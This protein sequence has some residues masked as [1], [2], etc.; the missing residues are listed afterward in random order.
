MNETYSLHSEF[1]VRQHKKTFINYLEV[2]IEESGKIVYAVPSHQETL[3]RNACKKY[4]ITRDELLKTVP[5]EW[6]FDFMIWLCKETGCCCVW[7]KF[8][9]G[10][11]FTQNQVKALRMLK[12]NGIYHGVLPKVSE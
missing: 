6:Y 7:N 9:T 3:I 4:G 5:K 1:D 10:Y 8:V 11:A 12:I 2:V